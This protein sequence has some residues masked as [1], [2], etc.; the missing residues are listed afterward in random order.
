MSALSYLFWILLLNNARTHAWATRKVYGWDS[1]VY[2]AMLRTE[3]KYPK[4]HR[5]SL[6][7][8]RRLG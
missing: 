2:A 7:I 6:R 1:P 5:M 8:K 3:A 4:V